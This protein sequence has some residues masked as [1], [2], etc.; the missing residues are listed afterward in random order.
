[1]TDSTI[2]L[3]A[4]LLDRSGSMQGIADDMRG[5]FDAYIAKQHSQPGSTRVTLAQFDD[6]YEIVYQNSDVDT[7]PPL[8]LEPRG[9]TAL[10]DSIGRFVTEIGSGLAALPEDQRP[11][12]VTVLVMT[13]GYENASTEWTVEAV[14]ALITQQETDYAWD[15][16]F[17]GANMDAV[18]VGTN[19]GFAPGKSLTWDASGDGVKGAFAAVSGY[20]S[21]KRSRGAVPLGSIVF[22]DSERRAARKKRQ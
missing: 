18:D 9:C 20:T 7:V 10:F 11:G 1:M 3:I 12:D 15:F 19:L 6:Q 5:G 21:R 16:V 17:L 14:R 13:D 22:E 8:V 2:T 4:A